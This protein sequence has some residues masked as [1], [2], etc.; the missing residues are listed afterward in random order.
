MQ[1]GHSSVDIVCDK[2]QRGKSSERDEPSVRVERDAATTP[3]LYKSEQKGEER[4]GDERRGDEMRG[5]ER[6]GE[7][8]RGVV[9]KKRK[10]RRGNG[11]REKKRGARGEI[12]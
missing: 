2:H 1:C 12:M 3:H 10:K 9:E 11:S 8:R 6:R 4:R 7:E 5:E